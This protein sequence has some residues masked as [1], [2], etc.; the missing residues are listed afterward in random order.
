ME[1]VNPY[2]RSLKF[3]DVPDTY[4]TTYGQSYKDLPTLHVSPLYDRMRE[5]E[6]PKQYIAHAPIDLS[7]YPMARDDN[8]VLNKRPYQPMS[9]DEEMEYQRM[10]E[11]KSRFEDATLKR[12]AYR[13]P[14]PA[15]RFGG[16]FDQLESY[17]HDHVRE[18]VRRDGRMF[19]LANNDRV[20]RSQ[21]DDLV[22]DAP[23]KKYEDVDPAE[24][25][26]CGKL[27]VCMNKLC[28]NHMFCDDC[29][30]QMHGSD[31]PFRDKIRWHYCC[32]ECGKWT[33][34]SKLVRT[35]PFGRRLMKFH[36]IGYFKTSQ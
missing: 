2:A 34:D 27:N 3:R 8:P 17:E 31:N 19:E 5:G 21:Y 22:V 11:E 25:K 35:D 16:R 26:K 32:S 24:C 1:P 29:M 7:P 13:E 18:P 4:K 9:Y 33:A 28:C 23:A 10:R 6:L 14:L 15:N 30:S 20:M 12:D 36:D